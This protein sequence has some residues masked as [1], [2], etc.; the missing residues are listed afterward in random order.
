VERPALFPGAQQHGADHIDRVTVP[1]FL[2]EGQNDTVFNPQEAVA[3][4]WGFK[5]RKV[6]GRHLNG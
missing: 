4:S 2:I 6:G 3:T 5:A 1:T